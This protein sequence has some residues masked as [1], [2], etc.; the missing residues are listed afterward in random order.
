MSLRHPVVWCVWGHTAQ[1]CNMLQH[2][3]TH[4]NALQHTPSTCPCLMLFSMVWWIWV[5]TGTHCTTPQHAATC[6]NML[7]RAA[8]SCNTLQ[9]TAAHSS[10]SLHITYG[11]VMW[12]V[13]LGMEEWGL[14]V[15]VCCSM[16]QCTAVCCRML[17]RVAACRNVLHCI[18][19]ECGGATGRASEINSVVCGVR[20]GVCA[21]YV[22]VVPPPSSPFARLETTMQ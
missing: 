15:A 17:P 10:V 19:P 12:F 4:C 14:Y 1:H 8:T 2:V 13:W 9:H 5:H 16:L 20:G 11:S 6:Y 18:P 22:C 21:V 7:Q 3:A